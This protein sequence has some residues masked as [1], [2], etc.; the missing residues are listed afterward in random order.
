MVTEQQTETK[1]M[2]VNKVLQLDEYFGKQRLHWTTK[3][4]ELADDLKDGNNLHEVASYTLSYRQILVENMGSV[5]SKIREKK[6]L[7]DRN[8]KEA[9]IRYYQFEYKLNDKQREKF[10]EADMSDDLQMYDILLAHR[11]FL[12]ASIKTLDNMGFAI[13]QRMDMKQL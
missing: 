9:W 4:R 5:S 11:E 12:V 1:A 7:L 13:K 10:I 6:A 2:P 8:Y 3:I